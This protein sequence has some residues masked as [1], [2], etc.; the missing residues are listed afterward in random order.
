MLSIGTSS[1]HSWYPDEAAQLSSTESRR[2]LAADQMPES[3]V[4]V[5]SSQ[6][7]CSSQTKN[8]KRLTKPQT[9]CCTLNPK[10]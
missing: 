5:A 1:R 6:A 3:H 7:K 2:L 8:D 9:S 4:T 10:P